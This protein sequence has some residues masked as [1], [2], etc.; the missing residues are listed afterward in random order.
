[1]S[2]QALS[3]DPPA[4]IDAV[5][6]WPAERFYWAV[7]DSMGWSGRGEIPPGLL[8]SL[9]DE[10][11]VALESVHA[12][13]APIDGNRVM[14]CACSTHLLERIEPRVCALVPSEIPEPLTAECGGVDHGRMNLLVGPF[15]PEPLRSARRSRHI[16]AAAA[17]IACALLVALG[18]LRRTHSAQVSAQAAAKAADALLAASTTDRR[19]Q[20][21]AGRVKLM[22]SI[23][24]AAHKAKPSNDAAASLEMFLKSWPT[25]IASKPQ[26][27]TVAPDGI[28]LGVIVEGDAA[29]LL[30]ALSPAPGF[31]LDEPRVAS[32]GP[33]TRV[34]LHLRAAGGGK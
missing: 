21:L 24:D 10:L 34:S 18:L 16:T 7:L 5:L 1:M 3:A 13:A 6:R 14:V 22:R 23:V 32:A 9:A 27:M 8:P 33:A 4:H 17:C 12:V 15:E 29:P 25:S 20:S 26:S 28:S 11:P 2:R 19:E 31:Q 30:K